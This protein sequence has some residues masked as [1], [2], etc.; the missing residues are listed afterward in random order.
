MGV[1]VEFRGYVPLAAA[2]ALKSRKPKGVRH[3]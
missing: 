3:V 1:P 2:D